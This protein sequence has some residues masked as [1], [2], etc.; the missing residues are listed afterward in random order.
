MQNALERVYH[1]VTMNS[2]EQLF[3]YLSNNHPSI[4]LLSINILYI[5]RNM[6]IKLKSNIFSRDIPVVILDTIND[7]ENEIAAFD[8]GAVD[9][10]HKPYTEPVMLRRIASHIKNSVLLSDKTLHVRQLQT[11]ILSVLGDLLEQ[12]DKI[13]GGHTERTSRYVQILINQLRARRIYTHELDSWD[14]ELVVA[15]SRLHDVGKIVISDMIL[16]KPG[17]LTPDEFDQMKI[18]AA[19]GKRIIEEMICH[20]GEKVFL[21]N[22][23]LFAGYHHERWD[24]LGYPYGL[25]GEDIPL[26]GRIMAISDVYDAILSA[27]PYKK[28][29]DHASAV[30]AIMNGAGTIFDP[31]IVNI[32]GEIHQMFTREA[33]TPLTYCHSEM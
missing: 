32:F 25:K 15:S 26:Q 1:V 4:I 31:A 12:R 29:L 20:T 17:K 3:D 11:G 19:E 22:A 28:A 24:G 27:R 5:N 13:T 7:T 8:Y 6:F 9:Y 23:K 30:H 14:T 16:N 10:I 21:N 18:H 2:V 33:T